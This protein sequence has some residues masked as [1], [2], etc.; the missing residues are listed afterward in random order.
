[1]LFHRFGFRTLPDLTFLLGIIFISSY[2][3]QCVLL[4]RKEQHNYFH[5]LERLRATFAWLY[6][7]SRTTSTTECLPV[8]FTACKIWQ[9]FG[10]KLQFECHISAIVGWPTRCYSKF[11]APTTAG[12][13]YNAFVVVS[14]SCSKQCWSLFYCRLYIVFSLHT[15]VFWGKI[16]KLHRKHYDAGK[17]CESEKIKNF[18]EPPN[19]LCTCGLCAYFLSTKM[20]YI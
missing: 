2:Q 7:A 10:S 9:R 12:T 19:R 17:E 18:I 13:I 3:R 4:R 5:Y 11:A 6:K 8:N 1:M 16:K 15:L 20:I 14:N